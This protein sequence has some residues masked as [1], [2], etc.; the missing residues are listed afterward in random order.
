MIDRTALKN[1]L[2]AMGLNPTDP[3]VET[4][5]ATTDRETEFT[6]QVR[7]IYDNFISLDRW[8]AFNDPTPDPKRAVVQGFISDMRAAVPALPEYAPQATAVLKAGG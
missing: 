4:L 6:R 5:A 1:A 8:I 2:I 3:Q 7:A